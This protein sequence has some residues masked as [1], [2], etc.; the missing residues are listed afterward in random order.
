[1]CHMIVSDATLF[2]SYIFNVCRTATVQMFKVFFNVNS[3]IL[4]IPIIRTNEKIPLCFSFE[5]VGNIYTSLVT[6]FFAF[7]FRHK[8]DS[9]K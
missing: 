5:L 4:F 9:I 6:I 2:H 3:F 8:I 7:L 1:M